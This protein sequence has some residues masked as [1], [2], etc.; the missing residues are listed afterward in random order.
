MLVILDLTKL[1]P[2]MLIVIFVEPMTNVKLVT[3]A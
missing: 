1:G 3:Q 2:N